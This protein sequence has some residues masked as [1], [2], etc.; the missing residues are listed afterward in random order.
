[1]FTPSAEEGLTG[2]GIED[3][4][5]PES[6]AL[7][8]QEQLRADLEAKAQ[9]EME[10]L[11]KLFNMKADWGQKTTD[12]ATGGWEDIIDAG[13]KGSKKL[14]MIQRASA[15]KSILTSTATGIAKALELPF[16]ANIAAGIK[17]AAAGA[18]QLQKVKG[19]FHDGIDNVP[20]TGT[21][22]LEQGERVVDN[23]LNKDLS[24]YLAAQN[25]SNSVTCLLYTSPSPRD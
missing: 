11:K 4:E 15:I 23:R 19:Q 10:H 8:E 2:P 6:K 18:V 22:L 3:V 12:L 16:P 24:S 1:M 9:I 17:A 13:A 7:T 25:P 14:R 5:S 21:Y 20:G